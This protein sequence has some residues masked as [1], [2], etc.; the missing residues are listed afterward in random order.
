MGFS[1]QEYWGGLLCPLGDLPYAGIEPMSLT[2]PALA[3]GF[4]TISATWKGQSLSRDPMDCSSSV[5]GILQARIQEW[6][7]ISFSKPIFILLLASQIKMVSLTLP[8]Y[9]P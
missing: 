2:S 9:L 1:R 8:T 4:F 6:V 3:S 7:A 5:H